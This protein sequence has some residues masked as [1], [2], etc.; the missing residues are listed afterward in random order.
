M[1]V[2][3]LIDDILDYSRIEAG[4]M[5]INGNFGTV[6]E[7]LPRWTQKLESALG[8]RGYTLVV[9]PGQG[10]DLVFNTDWDAL[11][12]ALRHLATGIAAR[13]AGSHTLTLT[14]E[15]NG[16]GG[17]TMALTEDSGNTTLIP[18]ASIHETFDHHDDASPTK[19]GGTGIEIALA[20]KF[21]QLINAIIKPGHQLD[22]KAANL[23]IVPD[24]AARGVELSQAA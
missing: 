5:P 11:G 8:G 10:A 15:P 19:Y 1:T 9:A 17:V 16:L 6:S 3:R 2:L 20:H 4:K 18:E 21:A 7:N 24:L 22:G 12:G 23:L 14:V 13:S